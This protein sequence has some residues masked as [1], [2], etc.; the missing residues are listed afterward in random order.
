MKAGVGADSFGRFQQFT[1]Q[2]DPAARAV[3]FIA[4]QHIGW[5]GSGT[6]AAMHA[7]TKD[8]IRLAGLRVFKLRLGKM[9]LHRS[10]SDTAMHAPVIQHTTWIK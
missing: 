3:P 9:G 6:K 10:L 7:F 2:P 5:T 8:G 1:H 4:S